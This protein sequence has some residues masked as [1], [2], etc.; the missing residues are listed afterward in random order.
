MEL[1]E[2]QLGSVVR[3]DLIE[4]YS[5]GY[6]DKNLVDREGLHINLFKLLNLQAS[7]DAQMAEKRVLCCLA[8]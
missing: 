5:C 8:E 1:R 7:F 4:L 2:G 6:L 3:H